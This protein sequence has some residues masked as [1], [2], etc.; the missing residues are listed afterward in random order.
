M[1]Q[2]VGEVALGGVWAGGENDRSELIEPESGA[3]R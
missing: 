1:N 3:G 2:R